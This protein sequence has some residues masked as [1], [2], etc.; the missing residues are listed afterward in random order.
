MWCRSFSATARPSPIRMPA[1]SSPVMA[2]KRVWILSSRFM[3]PDFSAS[4]TVF[5]RSSK[6]RPAMERR[7]KPSV[8]AA[9]Q[10][11]AFAE[12]QRQT[13]SLAPAGGPSNDG[14]VTLESVAKMSEA[15]L[16]AMPKAK[17]DEMMRKL[18]GG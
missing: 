7:W 5:A 11:Q 12:A 13:Q 2:W 4:A 9:A 6:R 16:A 1:P 8:L 3:W 18:M 14:G 10:V 15:E 17:R